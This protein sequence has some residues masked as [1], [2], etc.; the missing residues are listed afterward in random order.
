[1]LPPPEA[2]YPNNV[3][4]MRAVRD[5]AHERGYAVSK[6]RSDKRKIIIKSDKGD[7]FRTRAASGSIKK[8]EF[9]TRLVDCPFRLT[10]GLQKDST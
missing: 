10:A 4:L 1:M 8:R 2:S 5:Y 9:A 7:C 3:A 6:L